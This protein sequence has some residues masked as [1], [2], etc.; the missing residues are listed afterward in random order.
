MGSSSESYIR[1]KNYYKNSIISCAENIENISRIQQ[2]NPDK[3]TKHRNKFDF[4]KHVNV[5]CKETTKVR[6]L[7][8]KYEVI[9]SGNS[10]DMG[11]CNQI[12]HKVK[13]KKDAVQ[14]QCR[15][16]ADAVQTYIRQ[17]EL[18][19]KKAMKKIV[20]D[21]KRDEF[22][23]T[24]SDWAAP[25]LLVTKNYGTYRLVVDYRGLNKQIEKTC[26]PFHKLIRL[27]IH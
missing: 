23:P 3:N 21:F 11:L 12:Y 15:C 2:N 18:L 22:E 26:W 16:C 5:F 9:V 7:C 19:E 4:E 14:M 1:I 10:N 8:T 24:H 20:E 27:L 6:S 25:S 13:I 17:H